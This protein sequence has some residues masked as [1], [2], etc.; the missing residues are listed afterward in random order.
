M[1]KLSTTSRNQDAHAKRGLHLATAGGDRSLPDA[2]SGAEQTLAVSSTGALRRVHQFLQTC[3]GLTVSDKPPQKNQEAS[4][5]QKVDAACQIIDLAFY[6]NKLS[7]LRAQMPPHSLYGSASYGSQKAFW[8]SLFKKPMEEVARSIIASTE[9]PNAS[10]ERYLAESFSA[11]TKTYLKYLAAQN[12]KLI[13]EAILLVPKFTLFSG[14]TGNPKEREAIVPAQEINKLNAVF[15][16][17]PLPKPG[18]L[19]VNFIDTKSYGTLEVTRFLDFDDSGR[20]VYSL[21]KDGVSYGISEETGLSD[22]QGL[23][24][25]LLTE[26]PRSLR[27]PNYTQLRE[28]IEQEGKNIQ[29]D[30]MEK[31]QAVLPE[32]PASGPQNFKHC[33]FDAQQSIKTGLPGEDQARINA[34]N[35]S[36]NQQ[37]RFDVYVRAAR[38]PDVYIRNLGTALIGHYP[39]SV[40]LLREALYDLSPMVAQTAREALR[41]HEKSN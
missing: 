10:D 26:D 25:E 16:D 31:I 14:A 33:S 30:M 35:H 9:F 21:G 11:N 5:D 17:H 8:E 37:L 40:P 32:Y 19:Q 12:P 18:H 15:S 20:L 24:P 7:G 34:V 28:A 13:T 23:F 36:W 38:S 3:L 27:F 6:G 41:Q 1:S 4:L 39:E 29:C 2:V 22:L